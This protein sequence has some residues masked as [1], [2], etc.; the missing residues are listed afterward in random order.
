MS[1]PL[2]RL[3]TGLMFA[4]VDSVS[5]DGACEHVRARHKATLLSR[6]T[7]LSAL[8]VEARRLAVDLDL[9]SLRDAIAAADEA[10]QC[11]C[12]NCCKGPS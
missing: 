7:R 2:D 10:T 11:D 8:L 4:A 5:D 9:D 12:S 3:V 1:N 6:S